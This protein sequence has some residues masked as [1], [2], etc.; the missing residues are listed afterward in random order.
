MKE[1]IILEGITGKLLKGKK[2]RKS[3][4]E[5]TVMKTHQRH[6]YK[7]GRFAIIANGF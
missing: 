1:R 7:I 4:L 5:V 6:I 2:G 3:S